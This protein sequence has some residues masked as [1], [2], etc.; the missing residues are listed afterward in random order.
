[1]DLITK[2]QV[3]LFFQAESAYKRLKK[4]ETLT[5]S[6]N[7]ETTEF[8]FIADKSK[9]TLVKSYNHSLDQDLTMIKGEEDFE[10]FFSLYLNSV[11]TKNIT[12]PMLVAFMFDGDT[13]NGYSA[14]QTNATIVFT[15]MNAVDSKL[16]FSI[17]FNDISV[18]KVKMTND[19]PTFTAA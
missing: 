3:A 15:D 1:M 8:E 16:N 12:I 13:T 19:V 17:Y 11:D 4:S 14:W 9:T 10:Y 2:E 18:G 5:I 6:A 7:A